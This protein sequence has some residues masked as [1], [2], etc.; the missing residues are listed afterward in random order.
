MRKICLLVAM[1]LPMYLWAVTPEQQASDANRAYYAGHY[2]HAAALYEKLSQAGFA[3]PVLFYNLGNAYFKLGNMP[4][5]ILY[6]EK[7]HKLAPADDD[8]TH[9]IRLANTR[10]VDKIEPVPVLFYIRWW[11][12][13][14]NIF[15]PDGFAKT[16]LTLFSIFW[17]LLAIYF[18]A[19]R[20]GVRITSFYFA[21][22]FL[23]AAITGMILA[24]DTHHNALNPDEA[25]VM[26]A[27]ASVKSSP[28]DKSVDVF[29]VHEGT[30]VTVMDRIGDWKE[31]RIANGNSGW[32]QTKTIREI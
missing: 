22:L 9:N 21:M 30:K 31:V 14:R 29:V 19:R 6:Y 16:S 8:I 12:S 23:I 20:R 3:S 24:A 28:D 11:N 1:I 27:S 4:M 5:A 10:L 2:D 25:I 15:S 7:A 18:L 17:I 32:I 13:A 26:E